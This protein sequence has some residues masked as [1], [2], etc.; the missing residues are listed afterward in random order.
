MEK[1]THREYLLWMSYLYEELNTTSKNDLY[2][3]QIAQE[4][5]RVLS[6][7]PSKIVLDDFQ[8]RFGKNENS[9]QKNKLIQDP[10]KLVQDSKAVWAGLRETHKNVSSR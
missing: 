3:M 5:R 6:K 9:E 8:I 2:L 1:T 4:V 10:N 7:K